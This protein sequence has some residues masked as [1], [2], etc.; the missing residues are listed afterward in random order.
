[1]VSAS[2]FPKLYGNP[3][4]EVGVIVSL[5]GDNPLAANLM[6]RSL[7]GKA[8][9]AVSRNRFGW[10]ASAAEDTVQLLIHG[11]VRVYPVQS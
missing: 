10:K 3:S 9:G 4:G 1:M 7:S 11:V 6:G 5:R 2:E 8:D